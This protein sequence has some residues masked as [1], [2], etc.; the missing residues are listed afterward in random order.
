MVKQRII[1]EASELFGRSGVKS[2]TMDDLAR[3]LSISKRTIYENF[4][5]KEDLLIACVE[6]FSE[7]NFKKQQKAF[8]EADNVADAILLILQKNAAQATQR[9]FNMINDIRKYYPQVFKEHLARF[10]VDQFRD[11]E[12]LI[13]RGINEGVFRDDLNPEIIALFFCRQGEG[14]IQGNKDLE[15]F[16]LSDIFDNIA[17]T[18]LRGICTAKGIEIINKYKKSKSSYQ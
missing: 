6:V 10:Q 2:I 3:H 4:K 11:M 7:E 18:F 8:H 17:I 13:Q 14:V 1:E 15:K 12:H 16:S 5:D 9:Q